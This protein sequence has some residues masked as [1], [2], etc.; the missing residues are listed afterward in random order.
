MISHATNDISSAYP[1]ALIVLCGDM[2]T[3]AEQDIIDSTSLTCIV[4]APT[5]G[6]SML[7]GIYVSD[8]LAYGNINNNNINID[9][10]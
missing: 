3:L 8:P 10:V 5:C 9:F 7:D 2:N 4:S 1:G 6:L